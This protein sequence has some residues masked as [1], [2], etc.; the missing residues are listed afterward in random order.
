MKYESFQGMIESL[1][2]ENIEITIKYDEENLQ[3]YYD[4]NTGMKSHLHVWY[5][6]SNA[7]CVYHGRYATGLVADYEHLLWCVK[8]C[9]SGRD[10]MN[11]YWCELLQKHNMLKVKTETITTT[12]VSYS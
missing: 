9:L 8:S 4:L 6:Q 3:V 11:S 10:F 12:T 7:S 5:N 1:V 2:K